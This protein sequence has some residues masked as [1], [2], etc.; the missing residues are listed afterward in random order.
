VIVQEQATRAE[1]IRAHVLSTHAQNEKAPI[2]GPDQ[3]GAFPG[4]WFKGLMRQTR[5]RT[6]SMSLP[7][8]I[9][10][11]Y[12]GQCFVVGSP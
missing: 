3:Y 7:S 9:V 11:R 12:R 8:S 4:S 1:A 10:P 5:Q 2:V 6:V